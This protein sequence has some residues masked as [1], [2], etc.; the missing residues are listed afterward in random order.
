MLTQSLKQR[1]AII[2]A[3]VSWFLFAV[4]SWLVIFAQ[5]HHITSGYPSHFPKLFYVIFFL[6]LY[7]FFKLS[8][9]GDIQI[10]L[11]GLL[12]RVFATGLVTTA[13]SLTFQFIRSI[14]NENRLINNDYFECLFFSLN[15]GVLTTFLISSFVVW[16][17]LIFYQKTKLLIYSWRIFV[18]FMLATLALAFVNLNIIGSGLQYFIGII[19]IISIFYSFNLKWAAYLSSRNKLTSILLLS[20][21]VA[22]LG[23]F[24]YIF[25]PYYRNDFLSLF[26]SDVTL[27]IMFGFVI[28]YA[29]IA[30]LVLLFNLP[31]SPVFEKKLQEIVNFQRLSQSYHTGRSV[32]EIFEILL[33]SSVSAVQADAAWLEIGHAGEPGKKRLTYQIDSFLIREIM[34]EIARVKRHKILGSELIKHLKTGYFSAG[35]KN[36]R[37]RSLLF[38]P[39]FVH[40]EQ[41]GTL[42]LLKEISDGFNHD[43]ISVIRT[44]TDQAAVSVENYRLFESVLENEKYI[45]ERNIARK[46]QKSLIPELLTNSACFDISAYSK[47]AD[48]VGG[49]YYDMVEKN[50]TVILMIADVSGKG[51]SAAFHMS[52]LKGIFH[53]LVQMDLP[54]DQLLTFA[55]NALAMGLDKSSFITASVF[56]INGPGKCIE[57]ARA[58]H[59]PALFYLSR[60]KKAE[61]FSGEGMGLGILRNQEFMSHVNIRRIEFE[62]NDVLLMFTDGI[63]EAKN[64]DREEFGYERLKKL[65]NALAYLTPEKIKDSIIEELHRFCGTNQPEDDYSMVILKFK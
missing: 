36:L 5:N 4:A 59:C 57:T 26:L 37:Y 21:T 19:I 65:F 30:V 51:I 52:L 48:E 45:S 53:S 9:K 23:Y 50:G 38:S 18:Y 1:I 47:S 29:F 34:D 63:S 15:T 62:A 42:V 33:D 8:V 32:N 41:V 20:L 49:D 54:P 61:Y 60:D 22:Y 2:L 16:E 13:V 56:K 44:F 12:W 3:L 58:G 43:M 28:T 11:T 14:T 31:T 46:V 25:L 27:L 6:S 39:L 7:Y 10:N 17:K 35:L 64:A 24:I 55:N 40:E